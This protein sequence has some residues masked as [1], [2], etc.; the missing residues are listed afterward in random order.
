MACLRLRPRRWRRR[1]ILP[2]QQEL[3]QADQQAQQTEQQVLSEATPPPD[4]EGG[5]APL[6]AAATPAPQAAPVT[7]AL[8]QTT[9]D[10]A[11][12]RGRPKQIVNLGPK[13]IWVYDDMKI[14]F[15]NGKVSDVQ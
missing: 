3:Q 15:V 10:V 1:Q 2:T 6:A 13:T 12:N 7:I 14:I 4:A 11:L 9:T 5:A 8:G